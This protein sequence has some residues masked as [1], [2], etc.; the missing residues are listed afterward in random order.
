MYS[1]KKFIGDEQNKKECTKRDRTGN[2]FLNKIT[3]RK[4]M[5]G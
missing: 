4:I 1:S 3:K 2:F 5:K